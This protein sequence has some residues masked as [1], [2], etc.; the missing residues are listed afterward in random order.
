MAHAPT[1]IGLGLLFPRA[2]AAAAA[3]ALDALVCG[4]GAL[5]AVRRLTAAWHTPS[6][7]L[8]LVAVCLA[9]GLLVIAGDVAHRAAGGAPGRLARLGLALAALA[10]AVPLPARDIPQGLVTVL[11]LVAVGAVVLQPWTP[12]RSRGAGRLR[13]GRGPQ[14]AEP[15]LPPAALPAPPAMP[16]SDPPGQIIQQFTRFTRPDGVE[17]VRGR[18]YLA[19]PAGVRSAAGH[20]G[21]C[22]PF[23]QTPAV[24]VT[25]DYDAV[26]AVVAASEVLPWGVRIECRLDEPADDPFE[27]PIDFT[28][29]ASANGPSS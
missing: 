13:V 28:A 19:V 8:A 18:L 14:A 25:T 26:E 27:I 2:F 29:D 15:P 6:G 10:V 21:F 23:P 4:G 16:P 22:P 24:E 9:G 1:N 11:A 3:A 20:I 7:P 17:C 12:T 5:L